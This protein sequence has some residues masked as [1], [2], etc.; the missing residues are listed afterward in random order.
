MSRFK[1]WRSQQGRRF[2]R[3][4]MDSDQSGAFAHIVDSEGSKV[5]GGVLL[6]VTEDGELVRCAGVNPKEA[7][8]A[9]LVLNR[10]RQWAL[11]FEKFGPSRID[12]EYWEH[13]RKEVA[14]RLRNLA[15]TPG[16]EDSWPKVRIELI[17]HAAMLLDPPEGEE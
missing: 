3:F 14:R 11:Q 17:A 15:D 13:E 5:P 4:K 2:V 16:L 12:S 8:R 10:D 6:A 7:E 9:G 1:I